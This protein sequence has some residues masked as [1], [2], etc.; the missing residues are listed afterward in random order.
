MIA[1]L[2]SR[3]SRS[4]L[5][6]EPPLSVASS[7]APA[8]GGLLPESW[9][10][11]VR[12]I[13]D[14]PLAAVP[15][16]LRG[17]TYRLLLK[18]EGFNPLGSIK[19][20]TAYSLIRWLEASSGG[21][22]RLT[23]VESTSGNLGCALAA[24]CRLRGHRFIAV[25]D[26]KV[27]ASPL[28]TMRK[29]GAEVEVADRPDANGNFLTARIER[30]EELCDRIPWA[31]W[32]NQYA[33]RANPRIHY[34]Q[35]GPELLRQTGPEV[36]CVFVAVSTGGTLRGIGRFFRT[37]S[38]LTKVVGVDV[39][40][41]IALGGRRGTRWLTGIGAN[42]RS[43][44]VQ[45]DD[46][47]ECRRVTDAEAIAL[48]RRLRRD[49]GLCLGGSSGAVIAATLRYLVD[50]PEVQHPVGI[51]PDNGDKYLSS[52]YADRWAHT[53]GIDV[54]AAEQ[55]LD[56]DGVRFGEARLDAAAPDPLANGR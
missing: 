34:L 6:L 52:I 26:P 1:S 32:V 17:R 13:G 24:I 50:H 39:D 21:G 36:D 44:F 19:D 47:D 31:C 20:R 37:A 27:A 33:S 48:C 2:S 8:A 22:E 54:A 42:R 3:S 18:L 45:D 4:A 30:V 5:A 41:S 40:G 16:S 10:E 11:L 9:P 7:A 14:T 56:R 51:C 43:R 28:R 53:H 29:L 46:Y 15:V 25:V 35:T 55:R 23:V 38:P 49:T 12:R